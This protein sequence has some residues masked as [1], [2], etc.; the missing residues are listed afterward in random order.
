MIKKA[1]GIFILIFFMGISGKIFAQDEGKGLLSSLNFEVSGG[2]S[3]FSQYVW[4]GFIMDR[5]A[6]I[7]P[8]I[9]VATPK[10]KFGKIK[11]GMWANQG[12]ENSD[13]YNSD[14]FDY[15][16]DYTYDFKYLSFSLGHTYYDFTGVN[17]FSRE[18]YVGL[19]FPEIFLSPSVYFYRDYGDPN[20]G[21]GLGNYTLVSGAYSLPFVIK[22]YHLSLDLSAHVGVNHNLF[23][24]GDG[25]DAG[26]K[27][28]LAMPLHKNLKLTPNVNYSIPFGDLARES[29]GNQKE[30]FYGGVTLI[31]AF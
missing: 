18:F 12:L 1:I 23:I 6:V 27:V 30:R 24:D 28:G 26:I 29:R 7:Q 2:L 4:R 20:N 13:D 17:K 16:F 31:Y 9:Y 10:T 19:S 15:I 25:G 3:V 14:E 8:E 21:G 11:I 22:G 5:D